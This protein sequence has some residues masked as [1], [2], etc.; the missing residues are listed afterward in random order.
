MGTGLL[1]ASQSCLVAVAVGVEEELVMRWKW[2]PL[3]KY[4]TLSGRRSFYQGGK[5]EQ[6]IE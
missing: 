6:H 5:T 3:L 2:V 4:L 1:T